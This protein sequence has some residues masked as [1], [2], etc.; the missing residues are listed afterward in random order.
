M[1]LQ[2][3]AA[4]EERMKSLLQEHYDRFVASY[5]HN[6]YSGIRVNTLKISVEDMIALSPWPLKPIP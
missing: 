5:D 3:P 6:P 1:A 4:F 2:L